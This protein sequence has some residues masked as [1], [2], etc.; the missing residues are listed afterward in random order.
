MRRIRFFSD[1]D[2]SIESSSRPYQGV[3]QYAMLFVGAVAAGVLL[4]FL[5]A[6]LLPPAEK[7]IGV[8]A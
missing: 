6:Y 4:Y 7:A 1:R 5:E 3:A 2:S 8:G